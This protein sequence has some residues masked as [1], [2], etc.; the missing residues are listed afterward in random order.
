MVTNCFFVLGLE[1]AEGADGSGEL[2]DAEIFGRSV[3]A[4]EVALGLGVPE[5]ELEAEGGG[6][7]VDSVVRPM[8]GVCLNSIARRLR[9]S[10]RA[11]M[12]AR[13]IAE[14]SR[15]WRDCAVSTTSVE[16]RP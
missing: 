5:Q 13:M 16:V 15:S 11:R 10:A 14:A 1:V 6:F 8:M 9:V 3:E 12:P 4:G 2:A 7:G